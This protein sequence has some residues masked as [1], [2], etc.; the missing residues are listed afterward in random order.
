MTQVRYDKGV[1]GAVDCQGPSSICNSTLEISWSSAWAIPPI[2]PAEGQTPEQK[3]DQ[4]PQ[5]MDRWRNTGNLTQIVV[6]DQN[7]N[8]HD[9]AQGKPKG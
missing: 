3:G 9:G 1:R 7:G 5:C 2:D 4:D 6:D 8:T